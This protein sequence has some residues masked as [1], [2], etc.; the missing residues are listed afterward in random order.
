MQ[1]FRHLF[2]LCHFSSLDAET[3]ESLQCVASGLFCHHH[4]HSTCSLLSEVIMTTHTAGS[5]RCFAM[6]TAS[7]RSCS[8]GNLIFLESPRHI[9]AF[10]LTHTGQQ[11]PPAEV[12]PCRGPALFSLHTLISVQ[13]LLLFGGAEQQSM[14]VVQAEAV[15]AREAEFAG[16][17]WMFG[18][19]SYQVLPDGRSA[20]LT[21]C[22]L[23][24][25]PPR[26][27]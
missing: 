11:S 20:A 25:L 18:S 23:R 21:P 13:R 24:Q 2:C 14:C 19:R 6:S 26:P 7:A 3:I 5:L 10:I 8:Q 9:Q 4:A 16:P 17:G 15:V 12:E 27:S 22:F 1:G